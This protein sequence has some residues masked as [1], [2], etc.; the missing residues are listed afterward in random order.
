METITIV[1]NGPACYTSND[2]VD[3]SSLAEEVNVGNINYV[4]NK[5]RYGI[6]SIISIV[7]NRH[8]EW[9]IK[10]NSYYLY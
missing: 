7:C 8:F 1:Y 9:S 5:L 10:N 4:A 6:F 3:P 2:I